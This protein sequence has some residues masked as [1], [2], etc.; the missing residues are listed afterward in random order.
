MTG[1]EI[2]K[3]LLAVRL[4]ILKAINEKLASMADEVSDVN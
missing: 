2:L 1:I 4:Q 3:E